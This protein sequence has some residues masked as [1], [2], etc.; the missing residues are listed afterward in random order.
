MQFTGDDI[1]LR[2]DEQQ[3]ARD[4]ALKLLMEFV[5]TA[6]GD[7]DAKRVHWRGI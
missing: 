1:G 6:R 3:P 7:L 5:N 2:E 4:E